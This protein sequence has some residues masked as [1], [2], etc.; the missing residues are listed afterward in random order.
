[1][2]SREGDDL[3]GD[4]RDTLQLNIRVV[5]WWGVGSFPFL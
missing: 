2:G 3:C 5:A 1:M 4:R